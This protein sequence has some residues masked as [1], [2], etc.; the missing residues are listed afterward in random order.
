MCWTIKRILLPVCHKIGCH[1][2]PDNNYKK[3]LLQ[4]RAN[5]RHYSFAVYQEN[6]SLNAPTLPEMVLPIFASWQTIF[7]LQ[8]LETFL[9][10]LETFL[11]SQSLPVDKQYLFY[12]FWK[13]FK[14]FWQPLKGSQT[15]L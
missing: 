3:A 2:Q 11:S 6:Q 13:P 15:P 5:M 7:V 1:W 14:L 9:F 8:F 12:N 4:Y 10:Y